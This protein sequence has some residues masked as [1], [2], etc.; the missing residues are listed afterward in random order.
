MSNHDRPYSERRRPRAR[1][2]ED[3]DRGPLISRGEDDPRG[4]FDDIEEWQRPVQIDRGPYAG[5]GPRNYRR[6]DERLKEEVC[7]RLTA[8]SHIDASEIDVSVSGGEVT[9]DGTVGDRPMKRAC[10]DCIEGVAGVQQVHNRL[11]VGA[12]EDH[13]ERR[14]ADAFSNQ[15]R[16]GQRST[17]GRKAH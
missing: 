1:R 15:N 14:G 17:T 4:R 3:D 11:G 5:R 2:D 13:E 9:L 6:S 12:P 7:D 10:E 16:E 8:N